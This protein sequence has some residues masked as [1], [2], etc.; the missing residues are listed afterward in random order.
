MNITELIA[1]LK[2]MRETHGEMPVYVSLVS[3]G[4]T[5]YLNS[6]SVVVAERIGPE[7]SPRQ[8]PYLLL[9]NHPRF[10]QEPIKQ[11]EHRITH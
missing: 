5:A 11:N 2:R 1:Y 10:D 8:T 9:E 3:R 4:Y 7:A 6:A